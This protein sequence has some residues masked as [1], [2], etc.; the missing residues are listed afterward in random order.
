MGRHFKFPGLWDLGGD[1]CFVQSRLNRS[2][3]AAGRA[4]GSGPAPATAVAVGLAARRTVRLLG[5]G[6]L[7]EAAGAPAL[8]PGLSRMVGLPGL[9]AATRECRYGRLARAEGPL[10]HSVAGEGIRLGANIWGGAQPGAGHWTRGQ[11]VSGPES[12][13]GRC[14]SFKARS[15]RKADDGGRLPGGPRPDARA[16]PAGSPERNDPEARIRGSGAV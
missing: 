3:L 7:A 5:A 6:R 8:K 14:L 2:V 4:G 9:E 13:P 15:R 12:L 16:A 1:L 10:S 11:E